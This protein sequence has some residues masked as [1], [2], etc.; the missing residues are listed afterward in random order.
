[1]RECEGHGL[2]LCRKQDPRRS[3]SCSK[4]CMDVPSLSDRMCLVIGLHRRF[5]VSRDHKAGSADPCGLEGQEGAEAAGTRWRERLAAPSAAWWASK[6]G[7]Q[8]FQDQVK[9]LQ[10]RG[11]AVHPNFSISGKNDRALA[12]PYLSV[13]FLCWSGINKESSGCSFCKFHCILGPTPSL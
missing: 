2:W 3:R 5:A 13:S 6:V 8:T 9:L 7:E 12:Q 10:L 4:K 11:E 1:M